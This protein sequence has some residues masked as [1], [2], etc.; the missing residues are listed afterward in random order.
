MDLVFI[1]GL[2][3]TPSC[4]LL[5]SSLFCFCGKLKRVIHEQ[6]ETGSC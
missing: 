5:L 1:R 4:V 3:K 2:L 6:E